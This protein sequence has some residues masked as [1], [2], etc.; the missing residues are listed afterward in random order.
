MPRRK[1][2]FDVFIFNVLL[3]FHKVDFL[4]V[5]AGLGGFEFNL[6]RYGLKTNRI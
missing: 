1:T 4:S 2:Q 5:L 6:A 3:R